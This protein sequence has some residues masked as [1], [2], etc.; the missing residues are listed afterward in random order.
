MIIRLNK[1]VSLKQFYVEFL[2]HTSMNMPDSRKLTAREI[3]IMSEFWALEGDL[4]STFRFGPSAKRYI[5]EMF[6]YKNYS[7]LDNILNSLVKKGYLGK[8]NKNYFI[9]KKFDLPKSF[10]KVKIEY[11]FDVFKEGADRGNS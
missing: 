2:T 11:S 10:N 3:E 4:V 7:N 1:S 9:L 8:E 6:K 5:R